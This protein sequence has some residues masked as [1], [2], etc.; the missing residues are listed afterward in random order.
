VGHRSR[1]K[2][3]DRDIKRADWG[4]L[5]PHGRV[6]VKALAFHWGNDFQA[7]A[8]D[9]FGLIRGLNLEK[10]YLFGYSDGGQA[11]LDFGIRYPGQASA[12]VVGGVWFEFSQD[13]QDA[14]SAAGFVKPGRVD[15]QR[16]Q[17]IAP[18]DWER[19][20]RN[21]HLDPDPEY[22]RQLLEGLAEMWWTPLNYSDQDFQNISEPCLVF[23]G[24]ND[25]W[26]PPAEGEA[27]AGKIPRGELAVIPG[28]SHNDVLL[29]ESRSINIILRYFDRMGSDQM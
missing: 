8:D 12:L 19:R 23:M 15:Y 22:P 1:R 5:T 29:P 6:A 9:L 7:M 26:I 4:D 24:E 16:Y 18:P 17:E 2:I 11:V 27:L 28:A 25:E 13:Y 3:E 10:P 20:F 21:L 14:I